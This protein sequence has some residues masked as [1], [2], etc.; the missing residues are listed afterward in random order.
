MSRLDHEKQN[1]KDIVKKQGSVP[2][3]SDSDP[4]PHAT[5]VVPG[6]CSLC[7]QPTTRPT[8]I[9]LGCQPALLRAQIQELFRDRSKGLRLSKLVA[10]ISHRNPCERSVTRSE[11]TAAVAG[12]PWLEV[13]NDRAVRPRPPIGSQ[14]GQSGHDS[15]R[16]HSQLPLESLIRAVLNRGSINLEG[17][18]RKVV[19]LSEQ[20][21]GPSY[22]LD[23]VKAEVD[24]NSSF[25]RDGSQ[26]ELRTQKRK[27]L[28]RDST[29]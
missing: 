8:G 13:V 27:W 26:V 7:D 15:S 1:K 6:H 28:P 18:H 16:S 23:R 29:R 24:G 10:L 9:C 21:G 19:A 4:G 14:A 11:I 20:Q 3:W 17:L 2:A 12:I 5:P 25:R 22:S